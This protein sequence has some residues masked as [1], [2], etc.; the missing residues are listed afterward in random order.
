MKNKINILLVIIILLLPQQLLAKYKTEFKPSISVSELYDDNIDLDSENEKSDWITSIS[1][2]LILNVSSQKNNF[3]LNYSPSIVRY[4]TED[5]NNT[6]RHSGSFSFSEELSKNIQFKLSDSYIQSE[7]PIEE[8]E[9]IIGRRNTRSSYQR[10]NWASSINYN[11][12]PSSSILFGYKHSWLENEDVTLDDGTIFD[13]YVDITYWINIKNGIEFSSSYTVADFSRDDNS[14]SGDD[15]SGYNGMLKY[16]HHFSQ[17]L[18]ASA[19]YGF[20]LRN[21]KGISEDYFVH[22]VNIGLSQQL[23]STLSFTL[24]GG[25]FVQKKDNSDD[26][27]GYV[28]DLSLSKSVNRGNLSINLSSGWDES[29]LESERRGFIKYNAISSQ[30]D[31]QVKEKLFNYAGLSY[32]HDEDESGR[33]TGTIRINYG[34]RWSFLKDYS[35]SLDYSCSQLDDDLKENNYLVNRVTFALRW[36]R[37]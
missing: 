9:G 29:Y 10:N 30:F 31:Y 8:T 16:L 33:K 6:I 28:F 13:P 25:Y 7:D 20:N 15:Y 14:M 21:F 18:T 36:S 22:E 12:A 3:S 11:F 23:S 19:D 1:P 27:D 34:W 2:A 32:R 17:H 24:S 37:R 4:K 26:G 35:V 5:Y